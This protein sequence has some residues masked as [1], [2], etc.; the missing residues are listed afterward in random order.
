MK[1]RHL[2]LFSL[3]LLVVGLPAAFAQKTISGKI[4]DT[5]GTPMPF[6][7]VTVKGT[8]VG[9]IANS[10]GHFSITVPQGSNTLVF[11]YVGYKPKEMSISGHTTVDVMM[12]EGAS[13]LEGVLVTALGVERS[14][15]SLQFSS[16][17]VSGEN[18]T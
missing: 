9:T 4:S 6:V 7:N 16:T 10:E 8:S 17:Q 5:R 3:L 18:F 15:K 14:K 2:F 13:E 12:E 1:Q 11:S